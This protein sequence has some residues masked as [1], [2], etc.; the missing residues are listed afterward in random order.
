M[1]ATALRPWEVRE[2]LPD[3]S[4]GA[5]GCAKR[6]RRGRAG[7]FACVAWSV[8]ASAC[9][10]FACNGR[11]HL[12]QVARKASLPRFAP[13]ACRQ[14]THAA[15]TRLRTHLTILAC[16]A[17]VWDPGLAPPPPIPEP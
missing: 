4:S 12:H 16:C 17:S 6:L 3:D 1:A 7:C 11:D 8:P 13:P 9:Q 10:V 14:P 15:A 5:G 2:G